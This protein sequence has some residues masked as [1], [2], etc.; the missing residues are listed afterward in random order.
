MKS[1]IE[2]LNQNL[3]KHFK[4]INSNLDIVSLNRVN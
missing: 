4:I 2:T 3:E 1:L